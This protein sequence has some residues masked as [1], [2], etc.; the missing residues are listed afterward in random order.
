[1]PA[2]TVTATQT[3]SNPFNG[4]LL[5]V[6]VLTG[7]AATASQTGATNHAANTTVSLTTTVI[8]SVAYGGAADS[9]GTAFTTL[10]AATTQ[11]SQDNDSTNG[12]TYATWKS[13]SATGTP[14]PTSFGWTNPGSTDINVAAEILAAGTIAE[15]GSSPAAISDNSHTFVQTA[16]FTPPASSLLV[17]VVAHDSGGVPETI[18]ITDTYPGGLTWHQLIFQNGAAFMGAGVWVA[19]VPGG[20]AVTSGPPIYPRPAQRAVT[21]SFSAGRM[22]AAHSQ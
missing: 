1:M 2:M 19:D 7:A 13:T 6:R 10:T 17:A 22:G 4:I 8:G 3:G 11:L 12:A 5:S 15:D 21:Q 18:T 14:G 9:A 20:G 16:S